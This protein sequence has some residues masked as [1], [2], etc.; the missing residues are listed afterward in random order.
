MSLSEL[1]T[2]LFSGSKVDEPSTETPSSSSEGTDTDRAVI[3][4][5]RRCGTTVSPKTT[6]CPSCGNDEIVDY[7]IE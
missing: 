2:T 3:H 4:E 7:Q 1:V 6:N 5:C